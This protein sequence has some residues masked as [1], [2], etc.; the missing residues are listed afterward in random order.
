MEEAEWVVEVMRATG[1]PTAITMCIGPPGDTN[2][3]P[4]GEC[5]VRLAKKGNLD[6]SV[7]RSCLFRTLSLRHRRRWLTCEPSPTVR[8]TPTSTSRINAQIHWF[9]VN[10]RPIRVK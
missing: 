9:H 6:C 4:P 8:A 3:V 7:H 2:N 10:R 5:A 1:K